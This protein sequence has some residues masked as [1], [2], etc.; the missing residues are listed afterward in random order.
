LICSQ[1]L[2]NAESMNNMLSY[3]LITSLCVMFFRATAS[4]HL[5][6]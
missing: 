1:G 4:V 5:V 3:E 2:G 6:K